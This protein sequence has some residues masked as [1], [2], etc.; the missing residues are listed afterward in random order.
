M[1]L[2]V[3]AL[4]FRFKVNFRILGYFGAVNPNIALNLIDFKHV[5]LEMAFLISWPKYL[6]N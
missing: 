6:K 5:F 1:L 3:W 4:S 2:Q